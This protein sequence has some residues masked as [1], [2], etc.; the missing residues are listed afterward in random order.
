MKPIVIVSENLDITMTPDELRKIV[1]DVYNQGVEDGKK[2][3]N[4]YPVYPTFPTFPTYPVYTS[5]SV[6]PYIDPTKITCTNGWN[7]V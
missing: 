1:D 6:V 7:G 3:G 5:P 2:L 4:S